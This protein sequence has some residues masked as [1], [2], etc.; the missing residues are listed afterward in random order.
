MIL[1]LIV[2]SVLGFALLN[3][4]AKKTW[5]TVLSLVLGAVFIASL[6]ALMANLTYHFGMEKE[7]ASKT[8]AL[9]SSGDSDNFDL[10]LYQPLGDGTEKVYLYKTDAAQDEPKQTGT[11]KVTNVV[12]TGA[13]KA[14]L[15]TDT[16]RWVYQS[17]FYRFLFGIA[18]NDGEFIERTNTFSV[19]DA[20]E[21]LSVDQAKKLAAL[22]KEQADTM[23]TEG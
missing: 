2:L 16:T 10:L 18:D 6:V 9:V 11:D 1:V 22:A 19:P 15:T 21:V 8:T 4:F 13:D 14:Q 12:E 3:V 5:Q 7:V 17:D 23:K 20:W